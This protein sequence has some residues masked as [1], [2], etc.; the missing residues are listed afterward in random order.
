MMVLGFT[1]SYVLKAI[2][3]TDEV[4]YSQL[5]AKISTGLA[6]LHRE[7]KEFDSAFK[8]HSKSIKLLDK[9]SAKCDLAEAY[10]QQALTHKK[11]GNVKTTQEN[12]NMLR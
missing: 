9:L 8:Y 4:Y 2:S 11:F 5:E 1:M 6:E 3:F 7:K 12:F 10:F